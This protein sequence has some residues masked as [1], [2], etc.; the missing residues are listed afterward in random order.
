MRAVVFADLKGRLVFISPMLRRSAL[1]FAAYVGVALLMTFPLILNLS[2]AF[3]GHHT[4]DA[5][6]MGH[7]IWWFKYALQNGEP[8]FYQTLLAYPHGLQGISLWA[9]PLQFFPAW[10]LAFV[11]PVST[12]YNLTILLTMALNGLAAYILTRALIRRDVDPDPGPTAPFLGGLI[13]MAAPVF[14]GH[15]FGGHAGL[16]V[17]WPVPLLVWALVMLLDRPPSARRWR[18]RLAALI[19]FVL[20][21]WGHSLQVIYVLLPLMGLWWLSALTDRRALMEL[22]AVGLIG[23]LLLIGFLL[24]VAADTFA[25][26]TYTGVRGTVAFSADLLGLVTPSYQHPVF[27]QLDYTHRVLGVNITEGYSY[28]GVVAAALVLIAGLR[29]RA[30]RW[31]LILAALAAVLAWGPVLK[32]LDAPLRLSID[33]QATLLTVPWAFVYELPGF[34]LARTPGRF[35]FTLALALSVLAA[36]G[37][38]ALMRGWSQRRAWRV[39]GLLSAAALF[40]YQAFFPYPT[41][42]AEVPDAVAQ[43]AEREDVRAVMDVPWGNLLAA[44]D[45]LY[46]QTWHQKPLIA[47]QVTRQTPVSP[48]KLTLLEQTLDPVLLRSVGVDLLI[49]HK[50]W[51][52]PGQQARMVQ[53]LGDP[54]YEDARFALFDV[55]LSDDPPRARVRRPDTPRSLNAPADFYVYTPDAAWL[56]LHLS[57]TGESPRSVTVSLAGQVMRRMEVEAGPQMLSLPLMPGFHLVR[58]DADPACPTSPHPALS[59][60]RLTLSTLEAALSP[61]DASFTP[62]TLTAPDGRAAVQLQAADVQLSADGEAVQVRLAWQIDGALTPQDLRFV[63]VLNAAGDVLVVGDDFAPLAVLGDDAYAESLTLALPEG[64]RSEMQVVA[65]WY[66]L[67]TVTRF[68][69]AVDPDDLVRLGRLSP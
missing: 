13:F 33:G 28:V 51:A 4:G 49:L 53:R 31:W 60:R 27:G 3:I 29:V 30:A 11:M 39:V 63:Q 18:W 34:S 12:A 43:V 67:P 1:V 56:D 38:S 16:M 25:D 50:Q 36:Y 68:S 61:R 20:S 22:T 14:Q 42:P 54:Y 35:S 57:V 52:A 47:G 45:G 58:V 66:R 7:H 62:V 41:V 19:F 59:C 55:P 17:M 10:A 2:T 24:P 5:Y 65:G 48:A 26:D 46:L 40:E 44:K 37:A 23:G 15:L 8:L 69:V 32:W 9:N 21:P 64:A 6:E